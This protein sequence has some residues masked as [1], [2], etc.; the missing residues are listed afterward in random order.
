[1]RYSVLSSSA[2]AAAGSKD[3]VVKCLRPFS[4]LVTERSGLVEAIEEKVD[5]SPLRVQLVDPSDTEALLPLPPLS[6]RTIGLAF[7]FL[8]QESTRLQLEVLVEYISE[9]AGWADILSPPPRV[10]SAGER[11]IKAVFIRK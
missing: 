7:S 9:F 3:I 11:Q 8:K 6:S 10:D 2:G 4:H 1:M 5:L